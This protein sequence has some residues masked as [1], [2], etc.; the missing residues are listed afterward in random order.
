M[1]VIEDFE[2]I[3]NLTNAILSLVVNYANLSFQEEVQVIKAPISKR[4]EYKKLM[5]S[6]FTDFL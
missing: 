6:I 3:D 1:C 4:F 5:C 2:V